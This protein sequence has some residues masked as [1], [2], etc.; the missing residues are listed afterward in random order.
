MYGASVFRVLTSNRD[1][2]RLFLAELIVFGADWFVMVPL[3]LLLNEKTGQGLWGGLALAAETGTV[4]LL[5][6]YAGTI[7][8]RFDRKRI[9]ITSNLSALIA[10]VGLFLVHGSWAGPIALVSVAAL[11]GAKAFYTP[12]ANA[13]MPNLVDRSDL[14]PAMAVHGAAWGT[15]TVL[16]SSLGGVVS[17]WLSPYACFGLVAFGLVGAALLTSGIHRPT[18]EPGKIEPRPAFAAIGEANRFLRREP[19]LLALVTVKSAVGVGNGLL[20]TFPLL[21][22]AFGVGPRGLGLMFAVRGLG[23]LVGPFVFRAALARPHWLFPALAISM[24]TY[25]VVYLGV[26]VATWFP[27]VLAGIFVAHAAGGGNWVMSNYALAQEVPDEL[28]GRVGASDQMIAMLA[29][30]VSQLVVGFFVD[31]VDVRL[32]IA[33]CATT[34]LLYAVGWR[35]VTRRLTTTATTPALATAD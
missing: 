3:L 1:F 20:A 19:R 18:R 30:T 8:D 13:A 10:V 11:S 24:S 29:V 15:V 21:A 27:L 35:L 9:L 25:G 7:A 33:C 23:S 6:P 2:R 34:T 22:T 12:A 31:S 32:L 16:A 14:S 5:L 17:A 28:R 26:S 4:A